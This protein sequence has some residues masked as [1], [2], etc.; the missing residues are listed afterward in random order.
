MNQNKNN[1]QSTA[2]SSTSKDG[3]KLLMLNAC[4]LQNFGAR[5][6]QNEMVLHLVVETIP[7]KAVL[8]KMISVRLVATNLALAS[9]LPFGFLPATISILI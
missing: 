9:L 3:I 7:F 4:L 2:A 8:R 1:N 5:I 6:L